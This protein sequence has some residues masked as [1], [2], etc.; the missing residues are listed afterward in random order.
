MIKPQMKTPIEVARF[1]ESAR[2]ERGLLRKDLV[3]R[4]RLNNLSVR[5]LLDG[6]KDSRL[7]TL[8]AVIDELGLDLELVPSEVARGSSQSN[9]NDSGVG[10]LSV[11]DSILKRGKN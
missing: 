10:V 4:T 11:V 1:L 3:S 9:S 2:I 7:S 6:S 5:G 8:L